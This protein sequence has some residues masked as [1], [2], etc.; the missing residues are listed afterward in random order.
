MTR[1]VFLDRDG[2]INAMV[3]QAE[4]GLIDSPANPDEFELLPGVGEAVKTINQL[5]FLAIVISNQPGMAKGK[6]T[7]ELL[8]ATKLKM[9]QELAA[10]GA[11]LDAVYYCVHHPDAAVPEYK[12]KCECRKPRPGLL[13]RAAEEWDIDLQRSYF[14]GDGI[15]DVVAGQRAGCKTFLVNSRKCYICDELARQQVEPDF[16]AKDLAD[17]VE[18][19]GMIAQDNVQQVEAYRFRCEL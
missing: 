15:S 3:Y 12:V 9:H 8:E 1:A 19:I 10:Y 18:A 4:F 6:F 7:E 11:H 5:G 16:M 14:V 17:A 13:L 2:V